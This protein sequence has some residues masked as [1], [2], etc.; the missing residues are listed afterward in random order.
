MFMALPTSVEMPGAPSLRGPP[1][2]PPAMISVTR[3]GAPSS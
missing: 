2:A 3:N 1:P